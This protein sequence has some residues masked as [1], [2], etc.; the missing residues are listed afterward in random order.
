MRTLIQTGFRRS[1]LANR[2]GLA[3]L[4]ALSAAL[5]ISI[6]AGIRSLGAG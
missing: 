6:L 5:L 2:V 3:L 4:A 1:R